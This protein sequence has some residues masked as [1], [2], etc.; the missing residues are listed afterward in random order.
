MT[1]A[2]DSAE[3]AATGHNAA[4][5]PLTWSFT[6]TAGDVLVVGVC[7]SNSFDGTS[8]AQDAAATAVSYNGVALTRLGGIAYGPDG[9]GHLATEV[10]LWGLVAPATGAHTVSVSA[11]F[12][13]A[14]AVRDIIAGAVTLGAADQTTPFG[15]VF[16]SKF[17]TGAGNTSDSLSVTGTTSGNYVV[18]VFACG[19]GGETKGASQTTTWTKNVSTGTAGDNAAASYQASSGGTVAM[20]WTLTQDWFGHA[21]VEVKAAAGGGFDPSTVPWSAPALPTPTLAVVGF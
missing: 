7:V 1:L 17:D 4:T 12:S 9:A 3:S 8:S 18:D 2:P 5:S 21:A 14:A 11:Q 15:S 13:R 16:T 20:A 10:S 6:N 19:S